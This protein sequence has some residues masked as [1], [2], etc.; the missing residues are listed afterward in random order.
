MTETSRLLLQRREREVDSLRAVAMLKALKSGWMRTWMA[1]EHALGRLPAERGGAVAAV[2]GGAMSASIYWEPNENKGVYLP[3]DAPS[4]F[5]MAMGRWLGTDPPWVLGPE[6]A[7]ALRG[8][9]AGLGGEADAISDL[10]DAIE[11]HGNI[12]IWAEY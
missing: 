10:M 8:F 3:V 1:E 9:S 12:R 4:S 5:L 2:A 6:S 7:L 11:K